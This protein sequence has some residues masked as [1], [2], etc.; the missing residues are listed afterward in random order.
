MINPAVYP[1]STIVL[2]DSGCN[3]KSNRIVCIDWLTIVL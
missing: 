2:Y 1:L 3:T